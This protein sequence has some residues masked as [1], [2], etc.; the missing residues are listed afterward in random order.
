MKILSKFVT[1]NTQIHNGKCYFIGMLVEN[2]KEL[3]AYNIESGGSQGVGN[4]VGWLHEN[5]INSM[6]LPKPGVECSNGLYIENSDNYCQVY[7]AI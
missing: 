4:R 5:G 2:G 6:M 1:T 7:Y 3:S